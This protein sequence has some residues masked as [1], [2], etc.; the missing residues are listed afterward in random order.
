MF[1]VSV[2][3]KVDYNC[4]SSIKPLLESQENFFEYVKVSLTPPSP[5][6]TLSGI[7]GEFGDGWENLMSL[8]TGTLLTPNLYLNSNNYIAV[9]P[10]INMN[11]P[12]QGYTN[13][14]YSSQIVLDSDHFYIC[15][16]NSSRPFSATAST[17]A[18]IQT[19]WT[20]NGDM[21]TAQYVYSQ[22]K[23]NWYTTQRKA[24]TASSRISSCKFYQHDDIIFMMRDP[25]NVTSYDI[26]SYTI[27]ENFIDV[28]TDNTFVVPELVVTYIRTPQDISITTGVG[29]ELPEHTHQEIVEMTVKSIL[30][31]IESQRYQSQSMETLESE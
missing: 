28:Y 15:N 21:S 17:G 1:L 14:T 6:Y 3:A 23:T 31:G 8:A 26:I 10:S 5:E 29:C 22:T 9:R 4:N 18:V 30:E 19:I 25:F 11:T 2:R 24:P 20:I 27:Q 16:T 12:T 13:D 7:N